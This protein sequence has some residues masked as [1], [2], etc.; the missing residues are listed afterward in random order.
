MSIRTGRGRGRA[1]LAR[2]ALLCAVVGC[3]SK[4][5]PE[6]PRSGYFRPHS[7]S[8]ALT[9]DGEILYVVNPEADSVS[10]IDVK[11][12][13]RLREI[14]LASTAPAVEPDSGNFAAAVFPRALVLSADA[15]T[16]YVTGERS[17]QVYAVSLER[18]AVTASAILCSEPV[19][20]LRSEDDAALFVACSQDNSVLRLDATSLSVTASVSVP[21]EPWALAWSTGASALLVTHL[22]GPGLTPIDP[23]AMSVGATFLVP[24][25]APRGDQRLAHG[26]ARGLYDAVVR[27][28]SDELWVAHT[29]LGTDTAQPDLNFESTA[30]PALSVLGA[31]GSFQQTLSTDAQDVPGVDGSFADVMSGPHALEFTPEGDYALVADANSEDVLLVD[32][33]RRVESSLVRPLPGKTP[34]GIVVSPDG[35]FAYVDERG[36]L[37][38]AVLALDRASGALAASVTVKAIP[39][40]AADPLSASL[41]LGE[42]LFD[43]ANSSAYPITT[44][45]WIACATCHMEGRS[46]AVT[47]L[48]AQ[49][50]RDTPSN[51]G[52]TLGTGFLFR[53]A[54]RTQIQDYFHTINVEQ[55]GRFDATAQA[56][57][58][59]ALAD[60]VNHALPLPVP[61]TTDPELV[62]RGA[63][64]FTASGCDSC[65]GGARFTDSGSGNP[66]LD[67]AG[68]I[69]LHD[70]G[71]CVSSGSFPDVAHAAVNGDARTAC[72]FDTPS[73]NG[74]AASPPYLH[75]GSAPTLRDAILEMPG[76]P[77]SDDDLTALVEFL[78]S[79]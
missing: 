5:S 65:H 22:L 53:T 69:T 7:S 56:P 23:N 74:I 2:V 44:D 52:G 64:V 45:H 63:S 79:L 6:S 50:P 40:V 34:E 29:L 17:G 59:D 30:F 9:S 47:W 71:T 1:G 38:I 19:G 66:T 68:P 60:Y 72:D 20:I 57:L 25:T 61:P 10:E 33:A 4:A 28:N 70:V 62:A 12:G 27:P 35:K 16:L 36:S 26:Q 24:D 55:G 3:G 43:S 49:G 11:R 46:D 67:F 58:L 41:R 21:S 77:K 54:D 42:Q 75:D 31:D 8:L 39:R 78:R 18:G 48:F 14:S 51:A 32:A 15:K 13:A 76:A 37:D 73:L